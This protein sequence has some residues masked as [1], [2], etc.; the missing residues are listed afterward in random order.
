ME[1]INNTKKYHYEVVQRLIDMIIAKTQK[2][3]E[4]SLIIGLQGAFGKKEWYL[5]EETK[6]LI[7]KVS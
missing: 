2:N 5:K 7:A 3:R 6:S 1:T 4:L